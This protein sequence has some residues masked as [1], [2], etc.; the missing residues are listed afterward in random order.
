MK[1]DGAATHFEVLHLL[2][3]HPLH[4]HIGLSLLEAEPEP[5]MRIVLLVR[6]VLV[7]Q[8]QGEVRVLGRGI[9]LEGDEGVD[10]RLLGDKVE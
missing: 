3:T 8:D 2:L 10:R 5:F 1:V 6:L 4:H 9:E 7:V